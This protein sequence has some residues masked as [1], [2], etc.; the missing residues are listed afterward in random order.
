MPV[1]QPAGADQAAVVLGDAGGAI[2]GLTMS[3]PPTQAGSGM[4]ADQPM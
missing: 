1:P 3:D 4:F 2:G